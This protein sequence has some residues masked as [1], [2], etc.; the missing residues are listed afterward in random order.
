MGTD[1]GL[2]FDIK[3]FAVHD[4][5]GIR[6]T[7]F[8]KGCPLS[9][10]WCHN[11]ESQSPKIESVPKSIKMDGKIFTE[12]ENVGRYISVGELMTEL[13]KEIVFMETSG[14]GVTFS[15]GEPLMQ[16]HFLKK[17][18]IECRKAGMHT[19]VDTS[20]YASLSVLKEICDFAD[21]FLYDVKLMDESLHQKYCGVSNK[22]ILENL[23]YLLDHD[24]PLRI[25]IPI[26]PDI[27]FREENLLSIRDFLLMQRFHPQGVD[28]LPFHNI[29][30]HK[31]ERFGIENRLKEVPN[32]P[33]TAL[34]DIAALFRKA[35]FDVSIGG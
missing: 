6:T 10:L 12:E 9:C 31:Y 7:V 5:P 35:G 3:R 29:A 30:K 11:P 14:G 28:L 2:I 24:F 25:R 21:L 34:S 20:G 18:L 27:T 13:Q 16:P 32:L 19:A 26:I 33:K 4:G 8:M 17:A 23:Q 1:K 15:G 22:V